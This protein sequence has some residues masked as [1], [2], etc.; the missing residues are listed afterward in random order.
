MQQRK[1][2]LGAAR[3][4]SRCLALDCIAQMTCT[5]HKA[6]YNLFR[7]IQQIASRRNVLLAEAVCCKRLPEAAPIHIMAA[8]SQ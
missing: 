7:H 6:H 1:W 5:A 3:R 4:L 8:S 2:S